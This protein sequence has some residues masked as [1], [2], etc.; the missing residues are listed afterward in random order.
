MSVPTARHSLE[1]PKVLRVDDN[2]ANLQVLRENLDVLGYKLW[3]GCGFS[4][5][6]IMMGMCFENKS[7]SLSVE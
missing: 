7:K 1:A 3:N 4:G 6:Y 5:R 2:T